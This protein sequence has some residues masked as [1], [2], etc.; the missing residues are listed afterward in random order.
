MT[1]TEMIAHLLLDGL[2]EIPD[3]LPDTKWSS[4][5]VAADLHGLPPIAAIFFRTGTTSAALPF[6]LD[7]KSVSNNE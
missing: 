4:N 7:R 3:E 6:R 1:T 5:A 2:L